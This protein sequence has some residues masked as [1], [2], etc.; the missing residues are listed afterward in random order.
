VLSGLLVRDKVEQRLRRLISERRNQNLSIP[1]LAIIQIGDLPESSAYIRQKKLFGERI[2]AIV[3][4]VQFDITVTEKEILN[5]LNRLNKDK[6][7]HGIII[8]LPLPKQLSTSV[9]LQAISPKKDVDGLTSANVQHLM[10]GD[11]K[12]LVPATARGVMSLVLHY[13]IHP[14]GKH[15]VVVGRSALVGGPIA[16]M[17]LNAGATVTVCHRL[18]R[19]LYRFTSQADIL[20][21]AAGSP[22]L[23]SKNHVR[24]GQIVIDVGI[25]AVSKRGKRKLVGDLDVEKVKHIIGAYTPVPGGVGPLTVSSLFENLCEVVE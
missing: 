5:T 18:T 9:V 16:Q 17:F 6:T 21:V 22:K 4:H 2:G 15:V 20:V 3:G 1:R 23:I 13:G 24:K 8:Q 12:G 7:T 11:R 25:T 10:S 19:P 14:K